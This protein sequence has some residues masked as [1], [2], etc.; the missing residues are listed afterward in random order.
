MQLNK[1]KQWVVFLTFL[2]WFIIYFGIVRVIHCIS[3]N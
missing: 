2:S 1:Q 3:W